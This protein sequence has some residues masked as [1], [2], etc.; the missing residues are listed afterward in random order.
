MSRLLKIGLAAGGVVAAAGALRRALEPRPRY[1]PWERPPY[2]DFPNRVLVLGGGFGGYTA[3]Q[4]LCNLTRGRDDVGV[5]VISR[6]N[7]FTFWPMVPGVIG[8]DVDIGNI[9][10]AL[11]RPLIQAGASFRR[12]ELR[13]ID[14]VQRR[15]TADGQEFPYDHLVLALGGQPNFFGI[16]AWAAASLFVQTAAELGGKLTRSS[17]IAKLRQVGTETYDHMTPPQ[18]VSS[19]ITPKCYSII[20][21][22]NSRWVRKTPY[23]YTC[24]S[25]V[26]SGV[27]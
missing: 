2:E 21:L 16:Y 11:R 1:A 15:V 19:K 8:S 17:M 20:Q 26:N 10:Q 22:Q 5:M 18:Y 4:T 24:G 13:D 3:A 12:A 7:F 9:A 27:S 23:P 6:E 25:L 14:F